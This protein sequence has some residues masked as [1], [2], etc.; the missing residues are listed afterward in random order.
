MKYKVYAWC[1][2]SLMD[3]YDCCWGAFDKINEQ[4]FNTKEEAE[5][6]AEEFVGNVAPWRYEIREVKK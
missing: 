5:A 4:V 1:E 2:D 3:S 6:A